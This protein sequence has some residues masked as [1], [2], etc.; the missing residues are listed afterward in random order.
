MA[1]LL[2]A[3][4]QARKLV[5]QG[6]IQEDFENGEGAKR[7][8][9]VVGAI[10]KVTARE[11]SLQRRLLY[12][13]REVIRVP[14]ADPDDGAEEAIF[15][16]NDADTRRKEQVLAAWDRVIARLEARAALRRMRKAPK[17]AVKLTKTLRT[18]ENV[19]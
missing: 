6:W 7:Y 15:G 17:P 12:S 18:V 16:W 5:A 1:T 13:F 3:A 4:R 8:Y 10:R 19:P 2:Q 14:N 9:C 11:S